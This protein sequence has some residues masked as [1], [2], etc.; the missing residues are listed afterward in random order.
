MNKRLKEILVNKNMYVA[1]LIQTFKN[2]DN[3]KAK[4]RE[5]IALFLIDN[6]R[7]D[8]IIPAFKEVILSKKSINHN[9]FLVFALG[10]YSDCRDE[11]IFLLK[12]IYK[13]DY[14]VAMNAFNII[15]DM[16]DID[17]KVF[18]EA[19]EFIK[20]NHYDNDENESIVNDLKIMFEL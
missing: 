15:N 5:E 10:E 6:F 7:D 17:D 8:R 13:F 18:N 3:S 19:K 9:A 4:E 16:C 2:L 14:H 20:N 11:L 12:I 1:E